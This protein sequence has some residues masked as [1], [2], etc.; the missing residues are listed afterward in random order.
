MFTNNA[1]LFYNILHAN[2]ATFYTY[3]DINLKK[4]VFDTPLA[5]VPASVVT[6]RWVKCVNCG[7]RRLNRFLTAS[8]KWF[9][10]S[11]LYIFFVKIKLN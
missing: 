10:A 11:F 1:E 2:I 6:L 4:I 3:R 5:A 9:G 7:P 8:A